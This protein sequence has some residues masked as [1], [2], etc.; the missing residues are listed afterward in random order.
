MAAQRPRRRQK[1]VDPDLQLGLA[2][3]LVGWIYFYVVLFAL[4]ANVPAILDLVINDS[5]DV[6]YVAAVMRLRAFARFVVVPLALTFVCMAVHSVF[7]THRFA[8]PL[9]R[10]RVTLRDMAARRPPEHVKL[11]EKD[12]LTDVADEL[13]AVLATQREDRARI[14]RFTNETVAAAQALL[15]T[16]GAEK[17]DAASMK[18]H[19]HSVL[20]A[21]ERMN[22]HVASLGA[23]EGEG[24]EHDVVPMPE[25]EIAAHDQDAEDGDAPDAP[26]AEAGDE[27]PATAEAAAS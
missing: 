14:Q 4:L 13:N 24:E 19:A 6:A 27:K 26:E 7:F 17:L 12:Y 23:P 2:L 25:A 21:A 8:G 1:L 5:T 18:S 20:D 3:H 15:E 16:L 11:R 9:Y 10:I 22:R